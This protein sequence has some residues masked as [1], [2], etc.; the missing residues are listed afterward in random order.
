MAE[1]I[2]IEGLPE[3][4]RIFKEVGSLRPVIKGLGKG[5]V[6][7]KGKIAVYPKHTPRPVAH[8]WTDKQRRGF[9]YYLNKGDIEVPYRR[10]QSSGSENLADK[11]TV[12]S[13]LG[14]LE[15]RVGNNVSYG[16]LVQG[17]GPMQPF[18]S[19]YH[20]ETG[21]QTTD[22]VVEEETR[23]VNQ[24]VKMEVDAALEGK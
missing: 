18:Q 19:Q 11:W 6:H 3:L 13:F 23:K 21:W 20:F 24:I 4:K 8:L 9:F 15:W 1:G 16:P 2:K 7:L 5:A 12:R 22:E 14:G 10:G 17:S